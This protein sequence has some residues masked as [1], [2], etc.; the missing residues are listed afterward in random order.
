[1]QSVRSAWESQVG[2]D[3]VF[4]VGYHDYS[5]VS[6]IPDAILIHYIPQESEV[7]SAEQDGE[8]INQR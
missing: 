8:Q 4:K 2:K 3:E 7:V 5:K 6:L 1:M